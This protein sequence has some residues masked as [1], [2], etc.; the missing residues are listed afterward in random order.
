MWRGPNGSGSSTFSPDLWE[1][2]EIEDADELAEKRGADTRDWS[3]IL[4]HANDG[5]VYP[6]RQRS[7]P[8]ALWQRLKCIPGKVVI[9]STVL[10]SH[11]H[12]S[13]GAESGEELELV[14]EAD[15]SMEGA[16][17]GQLPQL[18]VGNYKDLLMEAESPEIIP[19][20]ADPDPMA[21][22][23]AENYFEWVPYDPL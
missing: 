10:V 5:Y 19:N 21:D 22:Y 3:R 16:E 7:C 15:I 4:H 20:P 1:Q 2:M 11:Q 23:N 8:F 9:E 17:E 13:D 6:C 14:D 18:M 12:E